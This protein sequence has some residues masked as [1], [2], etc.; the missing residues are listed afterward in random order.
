MIAPTRRPTW[1][2]SSRG[3]QCSA[4]ICATPSSTP[5]SIDGV[6]AAGHASPRPAG[7]SAAPGRRGGAAASSRG[8]AEQDRG[9]RVV[10]AAVAD[11]RRRWSGTGRP[12]RRPA[13]AR[14]CRRAA[15]SSGPSR[16][17]V[18]HH[19][20]AAGQHLR[21]AGPNAAQV[22]D[23]QLG[24]AVLGERELGMRVQI[25]PHATSRRTA[26]RAAP[27]LTRLTGTGR[28]ASRRAAGRRPA[29]RA[30]VRGGDRAL[31]LVARAA[32]D[33]PRDQS[34]ARPRSRAGGPIGSR[35][36]TRS[37][38]ASRTGCTR[39]GVVDDDLGVQAVARRPPLVLAHQPRPRLGS[40]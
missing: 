14:R 3:S 13:A 12:S 5:A 7:R 15:R 6:G 29:Q 4:K 8:R 40:V 28:P 22:L 1:P 24:R 26:R 19:A 38:I 27:S 36:S 25:A 37:M 31:A 9:V 30:V 39:A 16:A 2:V 17:D 23:D 34:P 21:R 35:S 33:Q 18:A 20:G 11:A 10:P 32:L